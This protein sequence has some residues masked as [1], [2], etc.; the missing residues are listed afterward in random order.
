MA[1]AHRLTSEDRVRL[2]AEWQAS[3]VSAA[4]FAPRTGV[5]SHTLY[6]WRR[7]ARAE[8]ADTSA[9][10]FT[11][12]VVRRSPVPAVDEPATRIEIDLGKAVVRVGAIFDDADLRRVLDVVRAMA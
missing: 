6:A 8:A 9:G 5:S 7:K 2:L 4:E 1:S 10:Q 3:G 12:L 11:E